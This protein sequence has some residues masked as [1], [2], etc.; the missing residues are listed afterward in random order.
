MGFRDLISKVK[1]H[2]TK[3]EEIKQ[4]DNLFVEFARK[5]PAF[6]SMDVTKI[7]FQPVDGD[8]TRMGMYGCYA[9]DQFIYK[10]ELH[11]IRED[12][13]KRMEIGE[14]QDPV[15]TY[16]GQ[17]NFGDSV[18]IGDITYFY[19]GYEERIP[20]RNVYGHPYS[21]T[22]KIT[23]DWDGEWIAKCEERSKPLVDVV[24]EDSILGH[25]VTSIENAFKG[26]MNLVSV[27]HLPEKVIKDDCIK[28]AFENSGLREIPAELTSLSDIVTACGYAYAL[29]NYEEVMKDAMDAGFS[30]NNGM[31]H[32]YDALK[33][34]EKQKLAK[35]AVVDLIPT[36]F[37][38]YKKYEEVNFVYNF[39]PVKILRVQD[40]NDKWFAV[41]PAQNSHIEGYSSTPIVPYNDYMKKFDMSKVT[42]LTVSSFVEV[43]VEQGLE[44]IKDAF[45]QRIERAEKNLHAH[46]ENLIEDRQSAI[47]KANKSQG[48][49]S[50]EIKEPL[51]KEDILEIINEK[52]TRE[53]IALDE[54][55]LEEI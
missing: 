36:E 12:M 30:Y 22:E 2:E 23:A 40:V 54:N 5:N 47:E 52:Q 10:G 19:E 15:K 21:M 32:I 27:A 35:D 8:I 34:V 53:D 45:D 41:S 55:K 18:K 20:Y 38:P 17:L 3:R 6:E 51:T 48:E 42:D 1:T 11:T 9:G 13:V 33:T 26:N 43:S 39:E 24:M 4:Q 31:R 44:M 49:I 25:D 14:N 29:N 7:E 28:S 37:S 50:I 46:I 16:A